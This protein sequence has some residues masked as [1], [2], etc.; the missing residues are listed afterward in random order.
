M[1]TFTCVVAG[2]E[3][4]WSL[5][6][7]STCGPADE[8][9]ATNKARNSPVIGRNGGNMVEALRYTYSTTRATRSD[10]ARYVRTGIRKRKNPKEQR[11]TKNGRS[12]TRPRWL[13]GFP[14]AVSIAA[15]WLRYCDRCGPPSLRSVW[16]PWVVCV[17]D[18]CL[19]QLWFS[20]VRV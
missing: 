10:R 3:V 18:A 14:P 17:I 20:G 13:S 5:S 7:L 16:R 1:V 9:L 15:A 6:R 8:I 4:R 11:F 2:A 12:A 19:Q